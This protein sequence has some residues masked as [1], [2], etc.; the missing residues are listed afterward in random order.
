MKVKTIDINAKLW[1]DRPGNTYF[2]SE[3]I[4]NYGL[5]NTKVLNIYSQYGYGDHYLYESFDLLKKE[6]VLPSYET[7][8]SDFWVYCKDNNIILREHK[9]VK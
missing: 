4:I 9:Q 8:N 3:I 1:R 2:S 6:G 7:G 5:K